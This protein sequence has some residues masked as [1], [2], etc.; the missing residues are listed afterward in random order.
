MKTECDYL[1]G[2][3]QKQTNNNKTVTHTKIS[4]KMVKPRDMAGNV[5]EEEAEE[6][7]K[8]ERKKERKNRKERSSR[9][10]WV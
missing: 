9:T 7:R 3:I 10:L 6:E 4:P 1:Y 5:E 8:K 2:L